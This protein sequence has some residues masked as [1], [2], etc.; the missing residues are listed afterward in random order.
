MG[1]HSSSGAPTKRKRNAVSTAFLG[2]TQ[3]QQEPGLHRVPGFHHAP[4]QLAGIGVVGGDGV[5]I[6]DFFFFQGC[7]SS[8]VGNK[9]GRPDLDVPY[10]CLLFLSFFPFQSSQN[11]L[12]IF[13]LAAQ[14]PAGILSPTALA[15]GKPD[16]VLLFCYP[17]KFA[18]VR[19]VSPAEAFPSHHRDLPQLG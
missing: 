12:Y 4:Q 8:D 16:K 19:L 18:P 1:I 2:S 6:A 13:L 7:T 3:K 10:D 14:T 11:I 5:D 17:P 9:K 15:L